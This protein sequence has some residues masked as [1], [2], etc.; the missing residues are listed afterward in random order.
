MT[1]MKRQ[2][3]PSSRRNDL[4]EQDLKGELLI[5]DLRIDK[6]FCLNETSALVW[7]LADGTK[8]VGEIGELM[9]RKL[10]SPV[11]DDLVRLAL[12][13]LKDENL[14]INDKETAPGFEGMSRREAVRKIGAASMITLPLITSLIAPPAASAASGGGA[15][16]AACTG[17][18]GTRGDCAPGLV[19]CG[20]TPGA[21]NCQTPDPSDGACGDVV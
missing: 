11:T 1:F 21:G 7:Q 16:G 17:T 15:A 18:N 5:Y 4:V 9:S 10:N 13:Q 2:L 6:A 19:C 14:L 8:S 20:I 3:L 12:D